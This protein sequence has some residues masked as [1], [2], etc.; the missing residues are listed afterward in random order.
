MVPV[1]PFVTGINIV[2]IFHTRCISIARS[3]YFRK[4]WAYFFIT[5]LFPEIAMYI[6]IR[7]PF[8]L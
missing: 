3:L 5:F 2:F 1:A 8:L 6:D 4:F 7:V